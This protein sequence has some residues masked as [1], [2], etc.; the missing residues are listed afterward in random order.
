MLFLDLDNFKP[1]NDQHGHALGDLLLQEVAQRLTACVRD[2]D[3]VGRFGGDEFVII[4]DGLDR[5]LA[6]ACQQME[7]IA[8][9]TLVSLGAPYILQLD[10]DSA[11]IEH[12]CT[13]SIGL[14]L[15]DALG[16]ETEIFRQSDAAMYRA[17]AAGR[18]RYCMAEEAYS[19]SAS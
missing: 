4:I 14:T 1:L 7:R 15:F 12:R 17:K 2:S 19:E 10:A 9:K 6:V 3:T 8:Q 13:A 18:N 16:N 11:R 5:E